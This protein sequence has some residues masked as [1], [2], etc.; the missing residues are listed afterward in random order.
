MALLQEV[1][2]L[3]EAFRAGYDIRLAVPRTKAGRSQR[4][5]SALLAKGTIGDAVPL[6][7]SHGWVDEQLAYFSGNILAYEIT[8]D[9][10]RAITA[11]VVYSPA[12]PVSKSAYGGADVTDVK[13]TQNPDVWVTDILT[14]ALRNSHSHRGSAWVVAGDFNLCESFDKWK[15][16]PRG[17]REWLER[18]E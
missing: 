1:G 9:G 18:M 7:S 14:A 3:P 16:G 5:K 8:L 15:G 10:G 11:V 12:W 2:T 13:L 17:N 4:F 6:S